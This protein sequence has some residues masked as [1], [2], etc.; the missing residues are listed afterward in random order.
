[1][2]TTEDR[3]SRG[4]RLVQPGSLMRRPVC[5]TL[6]W[7]PDSRAVVFGYDGGIAAVPVDGGEGFGVTR[8]LA[9]GMQDLGPTPIFLVD[10]IVL[11][12]KSVY[13][14]PEGREIH[15]SEMA[16]PLEDGRPVLDALELAHPDVMET[17]GPTS[18]DYLLYPMAHRW[19]VFPA[20]DFRADRLWAASPATVWWA[21]G[22]TIRAI[23]T[24][25]PT[26]TNEVQGMGTVVWLGYDETHR[27]LAWAA[28]REVERRPEDG[29]ATETILRA[30]VP[31]GAALPSRTGSRVGFAAGDS[32][33]VWTPA[34][35]SVG[36]V[37]LAGGKPVA[38]F[39][40]PGGEVLVSTQAGR[41]LAP[42]LAR[43][44]FAAGRLE[45]LAVP[46]VKGG[47]FLPVS[48]GAR[49]LLC[50]PAARPPA[51]LNVLD[52]RTGVW[53][54]VENPGLAGWEPLEPR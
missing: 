23:R 10:A 5:N 46:R 6:E 49:L 4:A 24:H 1:M 52:V 43:A 31:I 12:E 30:S 44:D 21:V 28:G 42:G 51:V 17:R 2:P 36:R 25:D 41:G 13:F 27:A 45:A 15:P 3:E 22:G 8:A 7:T 50:D 53:T 33:L 39:E 26:P 20:S 19:R 54:T 48:R 9:V 16:V 29:G 37:A 38:L 32:L 47:V 40:G 34:S 18:A 14:R 11:R 35:G